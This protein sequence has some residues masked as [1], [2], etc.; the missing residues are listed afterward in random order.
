MEKP[1]LDFESLSLVEQM[2][3]IESEI[4]THIRPMIVLDGGD[5]E[6]VDLKKD[7]E[8]L[9]L[10]I[11]YHGACVGCPS[12]STGTLT[13]IQQF[14]HVQLSEKIEVIPAEFRSL[15]EE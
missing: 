15:E 8:Q 5:I 4:D 11:Q 6:I 3:T 9:L 1:E 12:A 7:G 10:F 2:R 14:L 13:A